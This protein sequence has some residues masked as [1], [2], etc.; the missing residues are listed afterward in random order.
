MIA[1]ECSALFQYVTIDHLLGGEEFVQPL[2]LGD[3][4]HHAFTDVVVRPLDGGL[5]VEIA[6][7]L[8]DLVVHH[9]SRSNRLR[10]ETAA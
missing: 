3:G 5:F 9:L 6:Q 8:D 2:D 7:P 10:G 1:A 4:V